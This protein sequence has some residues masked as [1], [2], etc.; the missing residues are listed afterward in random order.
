[1]SLFQVDKSGFYVVKMMPINF[2]ITKFIHRLNCW[3]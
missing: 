1:V 2:C 3:S